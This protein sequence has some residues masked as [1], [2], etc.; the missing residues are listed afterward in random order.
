MEVACTQ[1]FPLYPKDPIRPVSEGSFGAI[2]CS[3]CHLLHHP[4][5]EHQSEARD[6]AT[7]GLHL[8]RAQPRTWHKMANMLA[9]EELINKN[10]SLRWERIW[11]GHKPALPTGAA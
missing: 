6:P 8:G 9:V 5:G 10:R 1:Q 2:S 11:S 3:I 4:Y 7:F